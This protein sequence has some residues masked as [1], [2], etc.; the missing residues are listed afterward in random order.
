MV[1]NLT[2][3]TEYTFTLR[4]VSDAGPGAAAEDSATP[5]VNTDP[6]INSAAAVDV[7][8]NTTA[9]VTVA[10][11]D[12]D[13]ADDI[14]RYELDGGADE[15]LFEI[16]ESTG[17]LSFKAAPNFEDAQDVES[18]TPANAAD[19]N[20]YIVVV[21]ATSGTGERARSVTQTITVTVT[22]D[23][24]EQP[25]KPDAPAV[26]TVSV[27]QL[28]ASWS[29][30]DNPGPAIEDY[31]YQYR[32]IKNPRG[33]DWT[34]VDD[35]TSTATEAMI[36]ELEEDTEYEVQVR[37]STD[38]GTGEWSD[39]GDG[40]TS[41][42]AHPTIDSVAAVDVAENTTAV[43]TV[44]ASDTDDSI[45]RYEVEGGADAA[46]FEIGATTGA[47]SF[48]AAPNFEDAQ[49]A[50][51]TTPTNDAGN[52][53]YI[54]VVEVTSGTGERDKSVTQ[55]ITVTVTDVDG[56]KPSKPDA[57]AVTTVSVSKV[58]V[59]WS[60]PDNAGPAIEDYDY[61]YRE[62]KDP[63]S[64]DWT[65]VDDTTIAGAEVTIEELAEDTEYEVQVRAT[66]GEGT[67]NWS[68]SGDGATSANAEPTIGSAAAAQVAENTTAVLT[69]T[70]SDDD[71][72]IAKYEVKGGVD[73]ALF[74]IGASTG[75]LSFKVAPNFED[76]QDVAS[77]DPVNDAANNE[78]IVVVEVTSGTGEREKSVTQ[79]ITVTVTD[80]I[81]EKPGKPDAPTVTTVSV[82]KVKVSWSAPDNA[83]PDIT[84]YDYQ[85]RVLENP[86]G[87]NWTVVDDT[88][89]TGTE[90]TIEELAE[91][92]EYEVQVR[93]TSDEGT[94]AWSDSG[95]G[96]TNANAAPTISSDAAVDV[97]EN[98]TAV[99]TVTASDTDDSIV[100]YE[101]D[102]GVDEVLFEIGESTGALSF[103]AAPNFEDAQDAVST[104]PANDAGNNEYIVVVKANSGAGE[105][106]KSVTQTIT[107]TVTD[108][109]FENPGKPDAPAVTTVSVSKVKVSWS[110]PDNAGPAITDYDYQYRELKD[111][112]SG[113]WTVVD[114]TAITVTEVTIEELAED[115]EY[116]VQVRASTDEGTC[117][118]SDSGEGETS[119]NADPTISSDAAVDVAENTTAVVTVTASDTDD[120]IES[121]E[122]SGGADELLFGIGESTGAL[123]FKAAPNFEDAQDVASTTPAN[124]AGNNEYIVVVEVTSGTDERVKSVTQTITV[125]V[126][127]VGGEKPSKPDAPTVTEV[128]VSR[129]KVNWSAPDNAGPAITDYDYQYREI[130][131]PRSGDWTVVD[132]TPIAGT[133]VTIEEL[134]EGTE[135]EVQVR[136]TSDE[137]TGE[138]SDSGDGATSANAEPTI[139]SAAAVEVAENTT[140]VLTVTA[141]DTDDSIES[142]EL[143]GGV[144]EAL[145]EIGTS[146]GAL[147]FKAAPNFEDAQD[148][149]S[150][151]PVNDAANNEY[152]VVVEVTS[153][154]GE[155]EKSVTQTIT[156]TVTDVIGEK[157][158]K[159]DAPTVTTV[160]V[161]KVKVSWSAPDNAGPDIADYD[162]QYRV[163]ENPRS[164][165][166]TVV[167]D[168]TITG[169]E[170]T[171]EELAE[172]TEYEVQVRATSDEGTG[173]WSDS[174]DGATNAN[175]APTIS[176]DAAV[177]VAENTTAVLTVTA[178]DTDDSIAKYEVEGGAGAALFEIG[179]STGALSFKA[180]PNFE[181]AQDLE[182]TTPANAAGNNAYIV[183]VK[184]TSGTGEREKSVSQTI[185]VTVT[186][187]DAE[188]PGKPDAP[189]VT[190]VSMSEVKVAWS[191]PDNPGPDITDYDYRYRELKT[192]RSGPWTVVD[193]TT[194]A[195]EVTI[196]NLKTGTGYEVQVLAN[197]DEGTGDWSESGDGATRDN[198]ALRF[199]STAN[200][201]VAENV[202]LAVTL[203]ATDDDGDDDC[204]FCDYRRRRQ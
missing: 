160:S 181:N 170:V 57:P 91:D 100:S 146:T 61:Q 54:V 84:D 125:T 162:Y 194:T 151:D 2:N 164:G 85:Y 114:D 4:A 197:S 17:A 121:F 154:T 140:A 18:T 97:A 187:D 201:S 101:L 71:D 5:A 111:P 143:D 149:A 138:W 96:A 56:E 35:V 134:A 171:I 165:N 180:A 1:S 161:S 24:F 47:L 67:G 12:T 11:S 106:A 50:L 129:V 127:D 68:D 32:E 123:S 200:P 185:T 158:G 182:S 135:Y 203:Q 83:G 79:T 144:D 89:I 184:A 45:E 78:Y 126:T 117:E 64:G 148:V 159:P 136:A 108:D 33:G 130:E 8:E 198:V 81:G 9:V 7:A 3:G 6:T 16:G 113:D 21:K 53:E 153:G 58:T 90:V 75:A 70:A 72:S 41:E 109:D 157:P 34:V 63:R 199:T 192:P 119:A 118:W 124:D 190:T 188:K 98:T 189:T 94:G 115:T 120:S 52:N 156:V 39:S 104:D 19:N 172:D 93:A 178:S 166:W 27:S 95:D 10:A 152:I 102:G 31:D 74:E 59:S 176:S 150:T 43:L 141:S 145:F 116:E 49:D 77:T 65:V 73:A 76:A 92:T 179:A 87:G 169:T 40:A 107:V 155:R 204:R 175:A 25:G 48:K 55:T 80:V 173:A 20:E 86:R 62:L 46:L 30:P 112:P 99:L 147:S 139:D 191:A 168:T 131:T 69:V 196:G 37:A 186:D 88:T 22:Y 28:K 82:S 110:A 137:G 66:S 163:L 15:A 167:D 13:A 133:E 132:D 36:E 177:D 183:V 60:A 142:Y 29:A 42:N 195:T 51:S 105:R 38:E 174:G 193:G 202:T 14:E 103:K 122:V 23:D 44:T 26:T 128:S